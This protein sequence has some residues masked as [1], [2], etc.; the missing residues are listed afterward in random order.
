MFVSS[1]Y[2][3]APNAVDKVVIAVGFELAVYGNRIHEVINRLTNEPVVFYAAFGFPYRRFPFHSR[4]NRKV[5]C[6]KFGINGIGFN[7]I[8]YGLFNPERRK[9]SIVFV[10]RVFERDILYRKRFAVISKEFIARFAEQLIP[11]G[12]RGNF[13]KIIAAENIVPAVSAERAYR[14]AAYAY[15]TVGIKRVAVFV[16]YNLFVRVAVFE[17]AAEFQRYRA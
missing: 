14:F 3:S 10:G 9:R 4:H 2:R 16:L 15:R 13:R 11:V 1:L 6:D 7:V 5:G 12:M 17:T 8:Q